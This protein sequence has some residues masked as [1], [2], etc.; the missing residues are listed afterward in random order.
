MINKQG[1]G[2]ACSELVEGRE[3]LRIE[4][5]AESESLIKKAQ[6]LHDTLNRYSYYYY[7]LDDPIVPDS[8]YDKLYQELQH[9]E[10]KYPE[11]KTLDSPTQRVGAKPLS[12]FESVSHKKP[13]LSLSNAFNDDEVKA[14]DRRIGDRLKSEKSVEYLCEPKFDGLAISILYQ[15]GILMR[16]ATRGDGVTGEDVTQNIKTVL[17]VPLKL[18]GKNY[19][20][21]IEVRGEVY[22]P[23]DGFN[24]LHNKRLSS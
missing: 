1:L 8:E 16:A 14:F 9:L 5:M 20:K 22:M 21:K 19:P 15:D 24:Q 7:V 11:L 2:I 10:E 12:A 13:M 23:K 6:K 4:R 17:T 18:Q 3:G